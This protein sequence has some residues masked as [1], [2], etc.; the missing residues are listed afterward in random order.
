M[1]RYLSVVSFTALAVMLVAAGIAI[2]NAFE[3]MFPSL[4]IDVWQYRELLS[5]NGA[6]LDFSSPTVKKAVAIERLESSKAAT[7]SAI[8]FVISMLTFAIHFYP[9]K[10]R[11]CSNSRSDG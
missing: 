8:A 9:L 2:Y 1:G 7:K 10:K 4:A 3:L 5:A 6:E 11:S